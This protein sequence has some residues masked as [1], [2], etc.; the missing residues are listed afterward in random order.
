V[1]G[2]FFFFLFFC[3]TRSLLPREFIVWCFDVVH[4]PC[5]RDA[6]VIKEGRAWQRSRAAVGRQEERH[7]G[8]VAMRGEGERE[9]E[10]RSGKDVLFVTRGHWASCVTWER[11]L[12][13]CAIALLLPQL[14]FCERCGTGGERGLGRDEVEKMCCL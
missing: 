1:R 8:S 11:R 13:P 3:D 12:S 2:F 6:G 14:A 4:V 10:R 7:A 5:G 9:G